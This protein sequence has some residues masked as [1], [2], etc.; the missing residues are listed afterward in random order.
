MTI[1]DFDFTRSDFT[2]LQK[3]ALRYCGVT[4]PDNKQALVYARIVRRL[5]DRNLPSFRAYCDLVERGDAEETRYMV[6]ALT[7]HVTSFMREPHHFDFLSQELE[8]LRCRAN[9]QA[10]R[11]FSAGCS[12][13]EEVYTLA[14]VMREALP[15]HTIEVVGGDV[16]EECLATARKGVYRAKMLDPVRADWRRRYFSR[17]TGS[18]TGLARAKPVLHQMT[19]F[20]PLN[21]SRP[22][23]SL[24]TF[25]V[26]MCRNVLIYFEHDLARS[27]CSRL[28]EL[29]NP[30]GYLILGHSESTNALHPELERVGATVLQRRLRSAS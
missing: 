29:L 28:A 9:G 8:A 26:V 27:I 25:D 4:I 20:R 11:A 5:R 18:N 3:L 30:G 13:G 19:S 24:G 23:P 14:M 15:A 2:R 1:R 12:T 17:G 10:V 21:L 6:G 22:L 16:D 7:T